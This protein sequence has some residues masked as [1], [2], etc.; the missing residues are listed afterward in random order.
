MHQLMPTLL[1]IVVRLAVERIAVRVLEGIT[2][3][4]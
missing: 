4:F 3:S 2:C 1:K